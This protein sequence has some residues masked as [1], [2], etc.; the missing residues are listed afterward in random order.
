LKNQVASHFVAGRDLI[1]AIRENRQP[2]CSAADGRQTV[3]MITAV[4]ASH[5]KGGARVAFPLK[6]RENPLAAWRA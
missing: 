2:L 3:E 4:F 5:I 6:E 1:R